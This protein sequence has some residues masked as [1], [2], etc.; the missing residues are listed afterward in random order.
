MNLL[1]LFVNGTCL[2]QGPRTLIV[3]RFL[4]EQTSYRCRADKV[5]DFHEV[6]SI[7][8]RKNSKRFHWLDELMKTT[9]LHYED[10]QIKIRLSS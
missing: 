7:I 5:A 4:L 10:A 6:N 1:M 3:E 9:K 8:G 2:I